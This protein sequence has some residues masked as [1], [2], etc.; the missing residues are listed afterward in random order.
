LSD[1]KMLL[2]IVKIVV[3]LLIVLLAAFIIIKVAFGDNSDIAFNG[4]NMTISDPKAVLENVPETE[5][6]LVLMAENDNFKLEYNAFTDLMILT[7]KVSGE[8]FR[9]YPEYTEADIKG[10]VL[11]KANPIHKLTSPVIVSYTTNGDSDDGELGINQVNNTFKSVNKI[12]NGYQIKYVMA[13]LQIEF[14]VEFT[15]DDEGLI[16]NVP[17]NGI[18]EH[19]TDKHEA[20]LLSISILPY[21][22]ANRHGDEGYYVLPD[23]SGA[24]T[25]FDQPRLTS[26]SVYEK[27]LYGSDINFDIQLK[28]DYIN[29]NLVMP[30]AGRVI[31]NS[32]ISMYSTE[33]EANTSLVMVKPGDYDI[34]FYGMNYKFLLRQTFL[35][36][37]SKTGGSFYQYED[38]FG[39][40][41][42]QV[43]YYFTYKND[44]NL[45][46]VDLAKEAR[47]RLQEDW[48]S[49]FETEAKTNSEDAPLVNVKVFLGAENKTG[50]VVDSYKALTTFAQVKEIY[51]ELKSVGIE[52]MSISLLGWQNGGYYGNICDKFP[53]GKALGGDDELENLLSWA[54]E[55]NIKVSLDYNTF[56]LYGAP[57]NG[58]TLRNSAVRKPGTE[59]LNSKMET[60]SG[61]YRS[62]SD[63][64]VMSPL[65]Y[66]KNVLMNDIEALKEYGVTGMDLQGMGDML[67]TDYN[68]ENALTR[69]QMM[70]NVVSYLKTFK[71]N[72]DSVSVYYG[73]DYAISIADRVMDIPT[74]SSSLQLLDEQVP[75][76]QIVYHGMVDYYCEP[77]NRSS[78]ENYS[79]LK[80]LESGSKLSYELTYNSTE[81]L[82]YTY[83]D[84]LFKSE[85]SLLSE[86][87]AED[88]TA[89]SE[90]Y[91]SIR[92]ATIE[93]HF[94]LDAE[95]EVYCTEYS[96]GTK[97]YVNY[98]TSAY[99]SGVYGVTINANGFLILG[100]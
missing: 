17:R 41:D 24:L 20:R 30:V 25:Y 49:D 70:H 94:R 73:N 8:A 78:N 45:S 13:A 76:I 3:A 46:Y 14:V 79:F 19:I 34:P 82:K 62:V 12:E 77:I 89:V 27:R 15:I 2:K 63:F 60:A 58:A 23:G 32:M 74:E 54:K 80:A 99:I 6:V 93:N 42:A 68:K 86:E 55:E 67:F 35:M 29:Q 7:N 95:K 90:Y 83:Y 40:G 37:M 31:N 71:E 21:F 22:M 100:A 59:Y 10:N 72:F 4:D 26:F 5:D 16:V 28:P 36:S 38:E 48:K 92:N 11:D 43:K 57:T 65:Y 96:N 85:Y 98:E 81:S 75:F 91:K 44:G 66:G 51:E 64:Y 50:G 52:S 47:V 9:S 88:Y 97:V 39:M 87:I 18:K 33:G 56:M 69:Q 53:A 1:K 61:A 84:K